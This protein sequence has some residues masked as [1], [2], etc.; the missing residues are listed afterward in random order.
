V[1]GTSRSPEGAEAIRSAGLEAVLADPDSPAT[2][3]Q[4]C[5]DVAIVVW[6]LAGATGEPE[7]VE[8]IHGSR[9]ER[10]LEKL[11]DTPVRGFV[12]EAAAPGEDAPEH[13]VAGRRIVEHAAE[14][15]RIRVGFDPSAD[16]VRALL[17]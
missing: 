1:R 11:V 2:I 4:L 7:T 12:Y 14:T 15:W 10:L 3:L 16:A 5:G 8:G 13:L 6:L 9:L 17:S